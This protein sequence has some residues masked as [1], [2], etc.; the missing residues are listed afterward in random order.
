MIILLPAPPLM[1]IYKIM[2]F[3][4]PLVWLQ[5][6]YVTSTSMITSDPPS[7]YLAS[8]LTSFVKLANISNITCTDELVWC[9]IFA[10][11]IARINNAM[12]NYEMVV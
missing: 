2:H 12:Q 5:G 8:F 1:A 11:N 3:T 6:R 4:M 10:Q 7:S 9:L